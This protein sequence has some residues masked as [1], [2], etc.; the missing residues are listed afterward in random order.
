MSEDSDR[1]D[2]EELESLLRRLQPT[3]LDVG[4]VSDLNR[5]RERLAF[6]QSLG[7]S[8]VQWTRVV[9]LV[10]VGSVVMFGFALHRF[11]ER[12]RTEASPTS[13]AASAEEPSPRSVDGGAA[14]P[15]LDDPR[16]LPLSSHGTVVNTSSGGVVETESGPAERLSVEFRDA[17]HWHDPDTGTNIRLF[18]PRTEEIIVPLTTD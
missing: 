5:E 16:F 2:E 18:R 1:L 7:P 3:P 13:L 9:P 8:R 12:L 15:V 11:G 6:E 17:F 14:P 4:L 10:L